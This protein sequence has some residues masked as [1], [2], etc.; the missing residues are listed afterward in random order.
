MNTEKTYQDYK[1]E[2]KKNV[3]ILTDFELDCLRLLIRN[4]LKT[5]ML[6]EEWAGELKSALA[7]KMQIVD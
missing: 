7:N 4:G 2:S 1:K 3:V 6:D 5:N